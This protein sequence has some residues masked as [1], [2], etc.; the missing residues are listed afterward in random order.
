MSTNTRRFGLDTPTGPITFTLEG[1]A[2]ASLEWG[3]APEAAPDDALA[4]EVARQIDAYFDRRLEMFDL[5]LKRASGNFAQAMRQA[6]INIPL[7]RTRTY[8]EIAKDL[9]VTAQAV[10]QG[11]GANKIPIIVPCHRVL[12]QCG[13]GGF[14]GG[15]GIETKV[16]LLRLESAASLL[17]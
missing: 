5:P 16:A 3:E 4:A 17:I 2:V 9:G 1:E 13:L 15:R 6:M 7:G 8:G 10:G 12:A 11:C 14:S